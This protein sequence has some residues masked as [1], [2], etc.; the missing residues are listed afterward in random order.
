MK[1]VLICFILL[2][3]SCFALD[4]DSVISILWLDNPNAL[5]HPPEQEDPSIRSSGMLEFYSNMNFTAIVVNTPIDSTNKTIT[6]KILYIIK[7]KGAPIRAGDQFQ[8]EVSLNDDEING[9][10]NYTNSYGWDSDDLEQY[11]YHPVYMVADYEKNKLE[12]K[13]FLHM[14]KFILTSEDAYFLDRF[15]MIIPTQFDFI[16]E[17]CLQEKRDYFLEQNME[18][19]HA[20]YTPYFSPSQKKWPYAEVLKDKVKD[21]FMTIGKNEKDIQLF[22]KRLSQNRKSIRVSPVNTEFIALGYIG[23]MENIMKNNESFCKIKVFPNVI[24][25]DRSFKHKYLFIEDN[26]TDSRRKG[27]LPKTIKALKK[28]Q[29]FSTTKM[30]QLNYFF[31]SYRNS[32]LIL[33]S[34]LSPWD[35]HYSNGKLV[36][37]RMGFSY[38]EFLS[39]FVPKELTLDDAYYRTS[40]MGSFSGEENFTSYQIEQINAGSKKMIEY[41]EEQKS[42]NKNKQ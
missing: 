14:N 33:D 16:F 6:I 3:S 15:G 36:D 7:N 35:F 26:Y 32:S 39:Y 10:T 19:L 1:M 18:L 17:G 28:G 31:G 24:F 42:K 41:C 8:F 20:F 22:Y 13:E 38:D 12:P 37:L 11:F 21:H 4:V 34:L 25:S 9:Y 27:E 30:F 40:I 5:V 23:G 2:V 29:C